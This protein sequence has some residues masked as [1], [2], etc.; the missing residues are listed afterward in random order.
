MAYLIIKRM[1]SKKLSILLTGD[2]GYN[3]L[4]IR[5][6]ARHLKDKHNLYI[7]GTRTQ[8]SGVGGHCSV[9][10]G[11]EYEQTTVDG[12]DAV[13]VDG[14]PADAVEVVHFLH[15]KQYDLAISGINW[16]ANV[17]YG[18]LS[19]T[20]NAAMHALNTGIAKKALILSWHLDAS[21]FFRHAQ[22]GEE[23]SLYYSYPG[24]IAGEVIDMAIKRDLW[25]STCLNINFPTLPS[26][27]IC[28]THPVENINTFYEDSP[29]TPAK[30]G[31]YS[32]SKKMHDHKQFSN[33]SDVG[34]IL[35]GYISI[36]PRDPS[37]LDTTRY[38]KLKDERIEL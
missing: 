24:D 1:P 14:Y 29:D 27:K 37:A 28:F 4:G 13:C 8:Q 30:K 20:V 7:A 16:G 36:T 23:I 35:H 17:G 22:D 2:D 19:G 12:I 5:L 33:T 32:Y 25:Q 21:N 31:H 11:F 6:V 9:K 18:H 15:K 34:A 26:R 10:N 38:Q 3:A